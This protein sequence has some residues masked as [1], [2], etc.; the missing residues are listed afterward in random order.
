MCVGSRTCS[1]VL[2]RDGQVLLEI[3]TDLSTLN[4]CCAL[5]SFLNLMLGITKSTGIM[6][7][8]KQSPAFGSSMPH[9]SF[10]LHAQ[11]VMEYPVCLLLFQRMHWV[12]VVTLH[13][14]VWLNLCR[15]LNM[16]LNA[17]VSSTADPEIGIKRKAKD[18][19]SGDVCM[20]GCRGFYNPSLHVFSSFSHFFMC[21]CRHSGA[22]LGLGPAK[23]KHMPSCTLWVRLNQIQA[24]NITEVLSNLLWTQGMGE[25]AASSSS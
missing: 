19:C 10:W 4:S 17:F 8:V 12:Y 21:D 18:C 2:S 13:A 23:D 22:D 7:R 20:S 3:P 11:V 9:E 5:R 1:S 6:F 24:I 16:L 15:A 25:K 14:S